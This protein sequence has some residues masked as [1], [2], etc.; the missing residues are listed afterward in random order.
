M[1]L[2]IRLVFGAV[3]LTALP[4]IP[5]LCAEVPFSITISAIP[6]TVKAGSDVRLNMVYTNTSAREI[7]LLRTVGVNQ[8]EYFSRVLIQDDRGKAVSSSKYGREL[9]GKDATPQG[10]GPYYLPPDALGGLIG[11]ELPPGKTLGD[12]MILSKLHDLSR[13]GKY[14]VQVER[15]DE[16]TKTFVKSNKITITVTE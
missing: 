15:F 11:F 6:D 4:C 12:G 7:T 1:L 3:A 14:T 2:R 9:T 5:A 16:S 8:G 13:P 10:H